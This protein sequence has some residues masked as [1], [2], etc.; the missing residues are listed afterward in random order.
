MKRIT[1]NVPDALAG[2]LK[3]RA[4]T[5]GVRQAELRYDTPIPVLRLPMGLQFRRSSVLS[6]LKSQETKNAG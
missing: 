6:W 3:E 5:T 4:A 2:E 1:I